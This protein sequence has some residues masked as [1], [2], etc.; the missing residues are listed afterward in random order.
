MRD[1]LY[2]GL[3]APVQPR[4]APCEGRPVGFR[5]GKKHTTAVKLA[6]A[7]PACGRQP[8]RRAVLQAVLPAVEA[9]PVARIRPAPGMTHESDEVL[10][11]YEP[12]VIGGIAWTCRNENRYQ[13]RDGCWCWA[14]AGGAPTDGTGG[15]RSVRMSEQ[16]FGC[17][18]ART[19]CGGTSM[20]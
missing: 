15:G 8:A 12:A 18:S 6:L 13:D 9:A 10:L 20:R 19:V 14:A 1:A 5:F 3:N 7:M 16:A 4:S 11:Q 2:T 17:G